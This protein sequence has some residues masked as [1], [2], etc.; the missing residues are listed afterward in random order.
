MSDTKS[1]YSSASRHYIEDIV[2]GS[3]KE[4]ERH[5]KA[6][7]RE[8]KHNDDWIQRSVN[9]NDIVDKFTPGAVGRRK[10]YKV[11]YVGK[12]YIV[13]ADMIA[14]YLRIIDKHT[15]GFVTLDGTVSKDGK[16]THFKILKRKDM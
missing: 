6:K 12:D 5:R 2:P 4:Q 10:G 15:G 13:L 16:E 7:E 11:K 3:E 1:A 8:T 9:I 14:G